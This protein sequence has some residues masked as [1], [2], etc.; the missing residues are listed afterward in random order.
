MIRSLI[1]TRI[2]E[3]RRAKK[4]SQ[5]ALASKVGISTSYMNL[6][7]H[8]H[9]TIAGRTLLAIASCL[10]VDPKELSEG[11]DHTMLTQLQEAA[12]VMSDKNVEINRIEEFVGRF[13]GWAHLSAKLFENI[14]HQ[15][16]K[17][18][19]LSDR[20]GH[21]PFFSEAMHLMLSNVTVLQSTS[22]ILASTDDISEA[23]AKKFIENMRS[24][25]ERLS[26]TI[27]KLLAYFD[28]TTSYES[29][30]HRNLPQSK[31]DQFWES[32]DYHLPSIE[33]QEGTAENQISI[34]MKAWKFKETGEEEQAKR[35]LTRYAKIAK[36]LPFTSFIKCA[37]DTFYN[38]IE[39]ARQFNCS[40]HDVFFRLAHLP[41]T[42]KKTALPHF[43]LIECDGSGGVLFRKPLKTLSLPRKSSACP[44]WPL[45][46]AISQPMHPIRAIMETPTG[47]SFVT[48]AQ[49]QWSGN[50][51]YSM[52]ETVKSAMLFTSDYQPFLP[53]AERR[54]FPHLKVGLTCEVC[55]R[56]NC[57]SRRSASILNG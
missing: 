38:P 54:A 47:E 8:N 46:R 28:E 42:H 35:L 24:E 16:Q 53:T 50:G 48:Y 34:A 27:T 12:S 32:H 1:G 40:L 21:D 45:Y 7:E 5:T 11:A 10:D 49:S 31:L 33:A 43:G 6:I 56:T 2:R 18:Q 25:S 17:L 9:R 37:Q 19:A 13:P 26:E 39:I 41:K 14:Q 30:S 55:P 57:T 15:E 22:D 23:Q 51:D 29:Q 20:L 44:I 52:P 4:L 36:T 3:K